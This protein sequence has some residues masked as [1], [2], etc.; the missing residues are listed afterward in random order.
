MTADER[1]KLI[2]AVGYEGD[3]IAN[4]LINGEITAAEAALAYNRYSVTL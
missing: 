1:E 4:K 3:A 2:D